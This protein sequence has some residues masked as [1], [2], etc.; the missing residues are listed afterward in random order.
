MENK[1]IAYFD[2]LRVIAVF[3]VIMI[4][5]SA[6]FVACFF[7]YTTVEFLLGNIFDSISRLGVPLF[8]MISG[9]LM[10]D[11]NRPFKC[12]KKVLTLFLIFA[13]WSLGYSIVFTILIPILRNEQFSFSYFF[14]SLT[15]GHQPVSWQ[16]LLSQPQIPFGESHIP[17]G[18]SARSMLSSRA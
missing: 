2:F 8:L 5:T 17:E 10:L 6:T 1:R 3:A 7:D 15:C 11:E 9:A 14:S 4:H 18:C 13:I 12:K 16:P